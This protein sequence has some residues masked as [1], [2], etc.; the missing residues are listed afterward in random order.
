MSSH[1][2][3]PVVPEN[4]T[5]SGTLGDFSTNYERDLTPKDRLRFIVRH[6]LARYEIPNELVQ[7]DPQLIGTLGGQPSPPPGTPPQLQTA[8]NFETMGSV[9][10]QHTFSPNVLIDARG[11]VR[12]N[13]NDFYSNPYS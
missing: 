5:N 6:E 2:L 10:Y 8:A 4:F 1:Y 13:S 7:Q 9:T 3:N 11:M 12:D